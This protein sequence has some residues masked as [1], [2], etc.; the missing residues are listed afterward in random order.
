VFCP[1]VLI[2]VIIS[3][4]LPQIIR[5]I[6]EE[7]EFIATLDP[8]LRQAAVESYASAVRAVFICQTAVAVCAFLACLPI[9]E[10]PLPSVQCYT[11]LHVESDHDTGDRMKNRKS[12]I[13]GRGKVGRLDTRTG[14]MRMGDMRTGLQRSRHMGRFMVY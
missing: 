9:E 5:R 6:R 1:S 10:N 3:D 8:P 4:A 14:D 13:D 11:V 7:T 2:N 12:R